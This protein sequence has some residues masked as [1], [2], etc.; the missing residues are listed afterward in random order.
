MLNDSAQSLR[1]VAVKLFGTFASIWCGLA[2]AGTAHAQTAE[3]LAKQLANP[4]ASLISVPFQYNYDHDFGQQ[5]G[6]RHLLNF[7]PVVPVSI[8]ENW[9]LVSRT[10]VP[11]IS[12][13]DVPVSGISESGLGDVVQSAFFSPKEVGPGGWIWGV[14]PVFVLPTA[15]DEVLGAE[16]WGAGPTAVALKQAGPWTYGG[17]A[18]HIWSFAGDDDR[19][20]VSTTFLQPFLNYTTPDAVSFYLN[21]EGT[22]DW[23]S[24][25]WLVPVNVGV[26]KLLQL[27]DQ[28]V[29]IGG[30]VGY[31]ADSPDNG[32]EGWRLRLN[33]VLL[34][35]KG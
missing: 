11:V 21:T 10:I 4:I 8:N 3:E 13:D 29:Q 2:F 18:N 24:E 14:G 20:D 30:G 1:R 15:S 23:K 28:P 6:D 35:P 17:L 25:Q 22:Y 12:Q 26:N 16:K 5:D 34:F 9:N 32:P 27:G 19:S 7:Q 31:W 33:F